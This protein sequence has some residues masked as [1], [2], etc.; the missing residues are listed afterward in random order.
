[1]SPFTDDHRNDFMQWIEGTPTWFIYS[2]GLMIEN[3]P[4]FGHMSEPTSC[5]PGYRDQILGQV[6]AFAACFRGDQHRFKQEFKRRLLARKV[7]IQQWHERYPGA[8]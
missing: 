7:Q 8:S 2:L 4:I 1:M 6:R 3:S 5:G